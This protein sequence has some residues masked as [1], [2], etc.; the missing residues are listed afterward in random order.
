MHAAAVRFIIS[1]IYI[2]KWY[3]CN[4]MVQYCCLLL[5][6]GPAAIVYVVG[7]FRIISC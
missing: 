2:H 3:L 4:Y 5:S 1:A 6:Y 7:L